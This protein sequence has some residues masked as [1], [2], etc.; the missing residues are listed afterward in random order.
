MTH[1]L[2]LEVPEA[3]HNSLVRKATSAGQSTEAVAVELLIAAAKESASDPL[4]E[5]IGAFNSGGSDWANR[6][7][8]YIGRAAMETVV[9]D[10]VGG[11]HSNG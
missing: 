9:D 6:H 10:E 2:T 1:I 4:E 8:H 5:F 11:N 3:V 7:D